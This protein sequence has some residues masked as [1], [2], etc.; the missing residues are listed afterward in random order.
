MVRNKPCNAGDADLIPGGS[1]LGNQDSI[2]Y[3]ATKTM[4][5]L[6]LICSKE[7]SHMTLHA[8]T[9]TQHSQVNKY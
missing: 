4:S 7:R 2:C 6:E 5:K 9:K 1:N 8:T 3:G